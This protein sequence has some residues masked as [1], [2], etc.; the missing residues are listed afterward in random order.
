VTVGRYT[1]QPLYPQMEARRQSPAAYRGAFVIRCIGKMAPGELTR[2]TL[3]GIPLVGVSRPGDPDAGEHGQLHDV[4]M[5]TERADH[6]RCK[7]Q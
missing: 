1:P 6:N 7:Y 4:R 3:S 5:M 2:Q